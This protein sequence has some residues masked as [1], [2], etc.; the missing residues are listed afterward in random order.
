[1]TREE[2]QKLRIAA[3]TGLGSHRRAR[4][5][6]SKSS[7]VG[8]SSRARRAASRRVP[9]ACCRAIEPVHLGVAPRLHRQALQPSSSPPVFRRQTSPPRWRPP[10]RLRQ[11]SIG[12]SPWQGGTRCEPS[13]SWESWRWRPQQRGRRQWCPRQSCSRGSRYFIYRPG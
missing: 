8:A 11:Q 5:L 3:S 2:E 4:Q 9:R 10:C 12:T 13:R 7:R 1:V 6:S